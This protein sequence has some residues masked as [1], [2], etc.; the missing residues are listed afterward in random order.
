MVKKMKDTRHT[1]PVEIFETENNLL[2]VE[3]RKIRRMLDL[4]R[5]NDDWNRGSTFDQLSIDNRDRKTSLF[6]SSIYLDKI[7]LRRTTRSDDRF[8][9]IR[10]LSVDA[11]LSSNIY[12]E[13]VSRST[14]KNESN[15]SDRRSR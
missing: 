11:V 10:S 15:S 7:T 4:L 12:I 2:I 1:D 9:I 13:N 3:E 6:S 14:S 8:I 5:W